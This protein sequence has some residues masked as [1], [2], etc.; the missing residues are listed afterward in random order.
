MNRVEH[1]PSRN[2]ATPFVLATLIGI[3]ASSVST[4]QS[5][6]EIGVAP[7]EDKQATDN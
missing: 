2:A 7:S 4:P 6:T 3:A 1:I 5:L